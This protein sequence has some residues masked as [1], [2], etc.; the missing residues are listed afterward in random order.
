MLVLIWENSVFT[1]K[2]SP[3]APGTSGEIDKVGRACGFGLRV[4]LG[5]HGPPCGS[6]KAVIV[7]TIARTLGF[8]L[9]DSTRSKSQRR[10][11]YNYLPGQIYSNMMIYS[12]YRVLGWNTILIVVRV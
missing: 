9:S 12:G 5:V 10:G 2:W 7:N 6:W 8:P 3:Y 11:E 1:A 4:C